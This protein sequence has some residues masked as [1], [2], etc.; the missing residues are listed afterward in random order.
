VTAR[1]RQVI[2]TRTQIDWKEPPLFRFDSSLDSRQGLKSKKTAESRNVR[3]RVDNPRNNQ[4]KNEP[5]NQSE[6]AEQG[7][8][9]TV[10]AYQSSGKALQLGQDVCICRTG[11]RALT[12][13][14]L[15][16]KANKLQ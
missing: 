16:S 7:A 4:T 15:R 10:G 11:L 8:D 9:I 3:N 14:E 2:R 5:W 1:T 13:G 6:W 12:A